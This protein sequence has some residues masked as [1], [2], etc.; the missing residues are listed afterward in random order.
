MKEQEKGIKQQTI[1]VQTTVFPENY[2][3]KLDYLQTQSA[4]RF[5]KETFEDKLSEKLSLIRVEA[6]RILSIGTGLQ[7]DLAGTQ[8]PVRFEVR[9][10]KKIAEV[11]HSLAKWKRYT[12][13]KYGFKTGSGIITHMDA[14]RKE[15]DLS[16]I[17]SISVD[18]WDWERAISKEDRS[19]S[20]LKSTVSKIYEAL[21]ETS[22]ELERKYSSLK[23]K[24]PKTIHFVHSEKLEEIYP[25]LTPKQREK[26]VAKKYGA[27]F[28]IGIGHPL[29]SGEPHDVRASD[30]DDWVCTTEEGRGLNGDII[31]WD[32]IREDALE[33]S[34]MGIRVDSDSLL[35]Q[36][37]ISGLEHYKELDFHKKILEEKLPLSIGGG[38]GRSRVCMF[39]LQKAH[40]GE[41]QASIWSKETEVESEA[42]GIHLL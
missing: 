22:M 20:Y 8:V 21:K 6:P 33:L 37:K 7:D 1:T 24:L 28:L 40:I 34:S 32:S 11:V 42:K 38:I 15:E 12:L 14:I 2:N 25:E 16:P 31:V 13:G 26:E 10:P 29:K 18:Q 9:S 19:L 35:K 27:V 17:H 41:V 23:S 39:L 5:V 36:L 30:Y 3:S 4:I